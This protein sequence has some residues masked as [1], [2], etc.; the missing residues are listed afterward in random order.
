MNIQQYIQNPELLSN[1][2]S[3]QKL[4]L[5]QQLQ[6]YQNKLQQDKV[7]TQT[8]LEMKQK[9]QQELFQELRN[10]TNLSTL[11][12]IQNY[13]KNLQS[14]FDTQLVQITKEYSNL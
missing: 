8:Q 7:K 1:L 9:E 14:E 5:Y 13:I 4:D 6:Q 10:A 12:E 2:T 3:Q 11:P